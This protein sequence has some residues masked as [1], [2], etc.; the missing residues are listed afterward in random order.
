M[1]DKRL[2]A[3]YEGGGLV[4][5]VF[6]NRRYDYS[7]QNNVVGKNNYESY[8]TEFTITM[9][10]IHL[11]RISHGFLPETVSRCHKK[12]NVEAIMV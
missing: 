3:D 12:S 1:A 9:T 11:L 10:V 2:G 4:K 5:S 8:R 6:N 7:L